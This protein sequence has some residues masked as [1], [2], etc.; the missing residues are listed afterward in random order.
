MITFTSRELNRDVS[1]AKRAAAEGPVTI[2]DHGRPTHV[3]MTAEEYSRITGAREKF[4]RRLLMP[5]GEKIELDL[6]ERRVEER[7]LHL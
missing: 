7:N 6:P 4:G 2:T 5:G 1:A 3:L